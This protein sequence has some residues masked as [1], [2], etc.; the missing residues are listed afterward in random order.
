MAES[1][2][3]TEIE[4]LHALR[5][6]DQQALKTIF[7]SYFNYLCTIAYQYIADEHL[8]KD[9]T[10]DVFFLFWKRWEIIDIK[11]SLKFYLLR[12]VINKSLNLIK[13]K[14]LAYEEAD[15]HL[16]IPADLISKQKELEAE[17]LQG[18]IHQTIEQLPSRCRTIFALSRYEGLSHK[19]IAAQLDISTKTIENQ[20]SKALK[21]LKESLKPY[22]ETGLILIII[23]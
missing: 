11:I 6:G 17:D 4:L 22:L 23:L 5:N 12:A 13:S 16:Q 18:V 9:L 21:I 20:I 14:R 19:E 15:E 10:Q 2:P 8:A 7:N 3:E 1:I